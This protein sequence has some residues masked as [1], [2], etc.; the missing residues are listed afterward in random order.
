M[1]YS[2]IFECLPNHALTLVL[3]NSVPNLMTEEVDS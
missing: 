2:P 3:R 1:A